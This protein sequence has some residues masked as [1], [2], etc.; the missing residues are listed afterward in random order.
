MKI[1][2]A[3]YFMMIVM[4]AMIEI[5]DFKSDNPLS[6]YFGEAAIT[7]GSISIVIDYLK[8]KRKKK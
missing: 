1:R 2:R 3:L 5:Y 8:A 4:G 7:Y 6:Q